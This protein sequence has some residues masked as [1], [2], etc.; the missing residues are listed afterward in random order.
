MDTDVK[1]RS[2]Y[3]NYPPYKVYFHKSVKHHFS[4]EKFVVPWQMEENKK[5]KTNSK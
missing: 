2:D 3:E 4:H 5:E 1:Y